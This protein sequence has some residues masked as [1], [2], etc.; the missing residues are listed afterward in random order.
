MKKA[1]FSTAILL[2]GLTACS[3]EEV[4]D[5]AST[6]NEVKFSTF[7]ENPTKAQVATIETVQEDG[8]TMYAYTTGIYNWSNRQYNLSNFMFNNHAI[9][10]AVAGWGIKEA[11]KYWPNE[12]NENG[13]LGKV[14]FFA[15][16]PDDENVIQI[17]EPDK[18]YMQMV[19]SVPEKAAE[20]KD[21]MT[22][23][24]KDQTRDSNGGKVDFE[25]DHVLSRIGFG[26]SL[27]EYYPDAI[28]KLNS[29][30]VRYG[31][32]K[33]YK[34][35]RY[36]FHDEKDAVQESA[37]NWKFIFPDAFMDHAFGNEMVG[38]PIVLDNNV[39][40]LWAAWLNRVDLADNK[41]LMLIPQTVE[42]GALRV[43]IRYSV[44]SGRANN[45]SVVHNERWIDIPA[46]TWERG[47]QYTYRFIITLTDVELGE[48]TTDEWGKSKWPVV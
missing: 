44:T 11:T 18:T 23:M 8:F 48:I 17:N 36:T 41:A 26:V 3:T 21:L 40:H 20:Q 30:D 19:Y 32:N 15:F 24:S 45:Q 7:V 1:L 28:I 4:V 43:C 35:A 9:Y 13:D 34:K 12:M 39:N 29:V 22:D 6:A 14:T 27:A 16:T 25:F 38:E 47:T 31:E 2:A 37:G 5:V 46:T 42:D 10:D 33:V